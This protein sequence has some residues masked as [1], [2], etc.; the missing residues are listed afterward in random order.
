MKE[1]RVVRQSGYTVMSNYH[2]RDKRLSLKAK[3][4]LSVILSLPEDWDYTIKGLCKI[5]D[6]GREAMRAA[7]Q[8]LEGA[9]YLTRSRQRSEDGTL[10]GTQYIIREAPE[11]EPQADEDACASP[12]SENPTLDKPTLVKPT[13][14]N[15]PQLNTKENQVK[16]KKTERAK[17]GN[18]HL[19]DDG[20]L[21]Q[22]VMQNVGTLG[23]CNGWSRDEKNTVYLLV[24]E[25]YGD[26]EC[27]GKPPAHTARGVGGLFRKL[28]PGGRCT[29]AEASDMLLT[30]IERGWTS[31]YPREERKCG[32]PPAPQPPAAEL[33]ED[34]T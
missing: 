18:S 12:K 10:A 8:E 1:C 29:F 15:Q 27:S 20:Q 21:D 31:V 23:D 6:T 25:F 7:L 28:A 11:Q 19:L 5:C 3:G 22:L 4:L 34:W 30:A 32:K 33:G 13:L 17:K 26:R 16:N 9:G 24:K 2:L 14:E